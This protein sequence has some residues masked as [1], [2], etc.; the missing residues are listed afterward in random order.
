MSSPALER[1]YALLTVKSFDRAARTITGLA[2]TPETD[3]SGDVFD[4]LGATF[5]NPLPLLREHNRRE[6]IGRAQLDPPTVDGITFSAVLPVV[7]TP[8]DFQRRVQATIDELDAGVLWGVSLGFVPLENGL[9]RGANGGLVYRRSEILE[10]SLVSIPA[11][12]QASVLTVK[13]LS[14][15][16]RTMTLAEQITALEGQRETQRTTPAARMLE[17]STAENALS[18]P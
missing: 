9:E 2:T 8:G 12:R 6:P 17:L 15:G 10:V 14:S 1:V 13:S 11:H 7:D 5:R 16:G 18:T 3:R 4:P